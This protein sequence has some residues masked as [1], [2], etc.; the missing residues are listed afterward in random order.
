MNK[1]NN[2]YIQN[3]LYILTKC[4]GIE[5]Y[6]HSSFEKENSTFHLTLDLSRLFQSVEY[7]AFLILFHKI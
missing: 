7:S 6:Q 4:Q 1:I 2:K 3:I 5:K